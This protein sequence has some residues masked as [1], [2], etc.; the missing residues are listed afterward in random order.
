MVASYFIML[1]IIFA[2]LWDRKDEIGHK[3]ERG[4]GRSV[5][6]LTVGAKLHTKKHW[7][8]N[9]RVFTANIAHDH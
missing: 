1:M 4:L 2:N 9:V 8:L 5:R 3:R 6:R 7:F